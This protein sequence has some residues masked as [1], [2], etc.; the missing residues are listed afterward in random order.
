M[1]MFLNLESL[2]DHVTRRPDST[3]IHL[4][5]TSKKGSHATHKHKSGCKKR[6]EQKKQEE[7]M[8]K[9]LELH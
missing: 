1:C 8:A 9:L 6:W 7:K 4:R 2:F 3:P 5:P